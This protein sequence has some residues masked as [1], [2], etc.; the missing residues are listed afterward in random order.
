MR[1]HSFS[2]LALIICCTVPIFQGCVPRID[3][4]AGQGILVGEVTDSS[5]LVQVRLTVG[6]NLLDGDLEGTAGVVEFILLNATDGSEINRATA[7]ASAYR[8]FIARVFFEKLSPGTQYEIHTRLGVDEDHLITGPVA[9]FKT[10]PGKERSEAVRFVVVTGMNYAKFHGDNRIDRDI[11]LLLNATELAAPY[12]GADKHLG[13]P[14]LETILK[15]KPDF[16]VGTGDNVYYDTPKEPRAETLT[17][18]RQKWHEQFVQPRY[19]SLF[20]KVPT[21]WEVDDHDY[22]IDD[23][24]NS[25]DYRPSPAEAR[26]IFLEQLPIAPME[27][28]DIKTY[29]THRV[30]KELQ[31]WFVENRMY[32]SPNAM[33]DGPGK[34]I[35]GAEQKAW[36]K[37][38]LLESDATFKLMVSPTPMIGPDSL[39]K[40]D[41]HADIGGF[42]HERDEF[43]EWLGNSGV[44][45]SNFYIICGDR[46]W[47][48]HS[49]SPEGI[50]EFASGALTDTN[51]R[52]GVNPGDE[53]STDPKGLINQLYTQNPNSG[54]F[55]LVKVS[56]GSGNKRATLT[57][58]FHDEKG[59]KLYSQSKQ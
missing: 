37:K 19:H 8:D 47:Q 31:I 5:A 14:A 22:R 33:E 35:W 16:F 23:G 39:H 12:E 10:L 45:S 15:M 43:F 24:D 49:I 40:T 34:T 1:F 36:L 3:P 28:T 29:R 59:V 55:L 11:H 41:N 21:Y 56:P 13:Y 58:D 25:G 9:S 17:E 42:Q 7:K 18:M 38:T 27:A 52:L 48:Y 51:S 6:E 53:N 54:G 32:R 50:Q 30:S 26:R 44:G 2:I 20:A 57:F 4:K 46:H